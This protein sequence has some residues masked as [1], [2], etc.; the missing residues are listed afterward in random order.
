MANNFD[1]VMEVLQEQGEVLTAW[2]AKQDAKF[3]ELQNYAEDLEMKFNRQGLGGLG[4]TKNSS[5]AQWKTASGA[6]VPSL[7]REQK[8]A[9]LYRTDDSE[10]FSIGDFARDAIVGSRKAASSGTALVPTF[11]G[12]Q[13][14]DMV[15]ARTV[16][17]AAGAQTVMIDGPTVLAKLTSGP[18]VH[19]HSEGVEDITESDIVAAPVT[20]NPKLLA[21]TI[22]LTVELV[23]DSPNL[24]DV[25]NLAIAGAFAAKL[26]ALCL[27]TLLADANIPK[28]LVSVVQDPAQWLGV[29]AAVGSA[30]GLNQ[31]L[32]TAHIGASADFVARGSQLTSDGAWLGRPPLL[33]TMLE[34]HSTGLTAGTALFGNFAEAFA[35]ALRSDLRIEIV[36]HAKPTSA[37]H[38]LVAHMRADGVTLQPGKLFKQLKTVI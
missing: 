24:S 37:T 22:P 27:A 17:V 3:A 23:A 19:Q 29:L 9:D 12:G 30:L 33:A 31:L 10:G 28:S 5:P 7:S 25:L 38:L 15:R 34:A 21:C 36:R 1:S 18:T 26:D 35:I 4:A 20:L 16:V 8:A 2:R 32:P 14:I 6:I 13:L 11:L